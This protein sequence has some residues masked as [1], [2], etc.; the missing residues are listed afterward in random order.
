MS[1][2]YL[3]ITRSFNTKLLFVEILRFSKNASPKELFFLKEILFI[4]E[5]SG[6]F[7]FQHGTLQN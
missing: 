7:Y 5:Y 6:I 4:Y 3:F 1:F 2:F